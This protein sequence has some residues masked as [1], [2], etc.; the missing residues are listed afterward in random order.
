MDETQVPRSRQP[1]EKF[2]RDCG[3]LIHLNAEICPKCGVR[4]MDV[5]LP[6]AVTQVLTSRS[7]NTAGLLGVLLGGLGAHK[8][9]LGKPFQGL[10]YLVMCWTFIPAI[11]GFIEGLNYLFMSD[12]TF[13]ARYPG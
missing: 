9:Y 5:P 1:N 6:T 4:Q 8:F 12:K 13:A 3:A 2:C 7:K 10:L 11:I